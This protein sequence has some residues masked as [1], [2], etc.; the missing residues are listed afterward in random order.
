MLDGS[1]RLRVVREEGPHS[2]RA[3]SLLG[4]QRL[5]F[6]WCWDIKWRTASRDVVSAKKGVSR[7]P[8]L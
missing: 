1:R 7:A 2:Q 8:Q 6:L 5:R 4:S 3:L